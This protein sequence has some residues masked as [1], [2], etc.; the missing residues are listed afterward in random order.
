MIRIDLMNAPASATSPANVTPA[1]ASRACNHAGARLRHLPPLQPAADRVGG[2]LGRADDGQPADEDHRGHRR[3]RGVYPD[4]LVVAE[5]EC[6]HLL[7]VPDHHL[8][9]ADRALDKPPRVVKPA[10]AG[11]AAGRRSAAGLASGGH[12]RLNGV[13]A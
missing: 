9:A 4:L 11:S 1:A 10:G 6:P 2:D 8:G 13:G 12:S 7:R 5:V 3:R